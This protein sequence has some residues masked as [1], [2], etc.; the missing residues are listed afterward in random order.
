[1]QNGEKRY[2]LSFRVGEKFVVE[3]WI[4]SQNCWR[5][6]AECRTCID[7][8]PRESG[9]RPSVGRHGG[10]KRLVRIWSGSRE[11]QRS[12]PSAD[13]PHA[14]SEPGSSESPERNHKRAALE[15]HLRRIEI[16][17]AFVGQETRLCISVDGSIRSVALIERLTRDRHPQSQERWNIAPRCSA[18]A[19]RKIQTNTFL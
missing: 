6:S 15:Q 3:I 18:D 10:I 16:W 11:M 9:R 4:H 8:E 19:E 17:R 1:M 5:W 7:F 13:Q 14:D 12:L 2:T